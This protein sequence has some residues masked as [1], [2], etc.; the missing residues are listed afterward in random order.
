M[1][2]SHLLSILIPLCLL[3]SAKPTSKITTKS[4]T[5]FTLKP[6]KTTT[7]TPS[8]YTTNWAGI[9]LTPIHNITSISAH[10]TIP[11]VSLPPNATNGSYTF[12][13]WAGIDGFPPTTALL[14]AGISID[15]IKSGNITRKAI[16][17]FWEWVPG[18]YTVIPAAEFAVE[19]GD[20][21]GIYISTRSPSKAVIVLVNE[22]TGQIWTKKVFAPAGGELS[23]ETAEWIVERLTVNGKLVTWPEFGSVRFERCVAGW[24]GGRMGIRRAE[25]VEIEEGG[26]RLA[27]V[28]VGG[29]GVGVRYLGG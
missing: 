8:R 6:P 2:L 10:L 17:V 29:G 27:S 4:S 1:K 11:V 3:A 20:G 24:R 25:V 7:P 14:Q 23:G 28:S 5:K 22:D 18:P 16:S 21:M 15:L 13:M 12:S 9:Y 26:R 19:E